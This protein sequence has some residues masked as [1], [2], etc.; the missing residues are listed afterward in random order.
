MAWLSPVIAAIATLAVGFVIFSVLGKNPLDAFHVFF[1]KPVETRY[2]VGELLLKASPL[3]LCALG[4]AAGYRANVWNIG[5]EGQLTLGA[6]CGGG[7]ALA[8]P[9]ARLAKIGSILHRQTPAARTIRRVL[10]DQWDA[11]ISGLFLPSNRPDQ[12]EIPS[13]PAGQQ[14]RTELHR[15]RPLSAQAAWPHLPGPG[16]QRRWRAPG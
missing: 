13:H 1:V 10:S 16:Q 7:V 4:L 3:M 9:L 12:D 14:Q 2:G 6:L 11:A 8:K 15:G 5:A